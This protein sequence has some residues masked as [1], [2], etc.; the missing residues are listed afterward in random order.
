M[1]ALTDLSLNYAPYILVQ[2]IQDW[3]TRKP[4]FWMIME[5]I[6]HP[7]LGC[8]SHMRQQR[9]L[10]EDIQLIQDLTTLSNTFW[11]TTALTEE[12]SEAIWYIPH[13]RWFP[14]PSQLRGTWY[15]S[16]PLEPQLGL[17]ITVIPLFYFLVL[18]LNSFF[19]IR[20]KL[21]HSSLLVFN[22][23]SKGF[24]KMKWLSLLSSNMN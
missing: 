10:L 12:L 6:M 13:C 8:F 9:V 14:Q 22:F 4:S 21:N 23:L 18:I 16:W 2:W 15:S 17:Y 11:K 7:Y 20:E 5:I 19:F 3:R 24:A 1:E